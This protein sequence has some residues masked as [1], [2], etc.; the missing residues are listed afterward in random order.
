M[1]IKKKTSL[2]KISQNSISDTIEEIKLPKVLSRFRKKNA[3]E[4]VAD[5]DASL[6][7][8]ETVDEF[9]DI[10]ELH[11]F[12]EKEGIK[13]DGDYKIFY[14]KFTIC[15]KVPV[16]DEIYAT[17]SDE[18]VHSAPVTLFYKFDNSMCTRSPRVHKSHAFESVLIQASNYYLD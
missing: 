1:I 6:S 4:T 8:Y 16:Y 3:A 5:L 11:K 13:V 10:V 7:E 12:L 9:R 2:D 15:D 14:V 18:D 17:T